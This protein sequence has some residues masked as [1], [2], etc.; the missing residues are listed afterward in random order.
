M[1]D[2]LEIVTLA[3]RANK[4]DPI[5]KEAQRISKQRSK[6]TKI[7][8]ATKKKRTEGDADGDGEADKT[9]A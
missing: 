6:N 3:A 5:V 1:C 7:G 9:D 2:D 8:N 4:D